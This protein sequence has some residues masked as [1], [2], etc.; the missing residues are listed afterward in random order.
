MCVTICLP[1]NVPLPHQKAKAVIR[2]RRI[3]RC[4]QRKFSKSYID[5]TANVGYSRG[6]FL[7]AMFL[8]VFWILF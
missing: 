4:L 5:S 2:K 3:A 6:P 8:L 7:A 1:Q